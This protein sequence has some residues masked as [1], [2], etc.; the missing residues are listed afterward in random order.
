MVLGLCIRSWVPQGYMIEFHDEEFMGFSVVI[1]DGVQPVLKLS[2]NADPHHHADHGD[3]ISL[4]EPASGHANHNS[5]HTDCSNCGFWLASGT[6]LGFLEFDSGELIQV[7][8]DYYEISYTSAEVSNSFYITR[9]TRA[10]P[11]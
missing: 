5:G 11:A 1:C 8:A 2:R 4:S 9:P 6:F 3:L 7:T 10:P